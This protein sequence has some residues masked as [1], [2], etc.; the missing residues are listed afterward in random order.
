MTP[1]SPVDRAALLGIAR[2]AILSHLGLA[3]APQHPASGPLAEERG[4]F[5]T[6]HVAGELRGCIGTFRPTGSLAATVARMAVAAASEDPRFRPVAAEDVP[7]LQ[8]AVS[9]LGAARPLA[10]PRAVAVGR[11]GL[12]VKRG[13]HRGTLLP[14]VAVEHGWSAE[15]FL[16]H[17]CLKA[18]LPPKA[19]EDADVT[20]EAFEAEEFGEGAAG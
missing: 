16:K 17:T 7:E 2:G 10:N 14:K 4:A 12:V 1:L 6:V 13:F 11:E 18:G 15:E 20:I 3:P 9:A 19:W 5:V 8:V